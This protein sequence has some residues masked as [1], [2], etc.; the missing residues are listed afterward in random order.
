[1]RAFIPSSSI[2][3]TALA[4]G[5]VSC[6]GPQGPEKPQPGTPGF[7]WANAQEA[8]KKG[9]FAEA[10]DQLD[11]LIGKDGEFRDR[12]EALRIVVASGLARG[13][14]EWANI[15]DDGSNYARDRHLE[16]KRTGS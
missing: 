13:E 3:V 8:I 5:L 9:E 7:T 16:F 15:W 2:V 10:S 14:M 11:K 1:M 4:L 12:A 6:G